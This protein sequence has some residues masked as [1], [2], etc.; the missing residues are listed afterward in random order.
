MAIVVNRSSG[1]KFKSMGEG[2]HQ[3]VITDV[4]DLGEVVTSFGAKHTVVARIKNAA[5]EEASRFY[6]PSLHEKS[7]LSKDLNAI[8]GS[9]P[10]SFDIES[11]VGQQVQVFVSETKKADGSIGA[12]VEKLLKPA[13]G[14]NVVPATGDAPKPPKAAANSEIS[15]DDISF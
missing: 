8:Y 2:L 9:V 6:T 14:Q 1:S 7:T 12:K 3:G 10:P 4:K 5:G 13:K 15:D 11:L